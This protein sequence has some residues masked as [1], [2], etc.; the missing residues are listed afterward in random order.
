MKHIIKCQYNNIDNR[1][2]HYFWFLLLLFILS[3]HGPL[4]GQDTLI[5]KS[6][7]TL[8]VYLVETRDTEVEY[9]KSPDSDSRYI[10]PRNKI[11]MLLPAIVQETE[12][13]VKNNTLPNDL[14][15]DEVKSIEHH[16]EASYARFDTLNA[17]RYFFLPS[18]IPLQKKGIYYQNAFL[19]LNSIN[20]GVSNNFSVGGGIGLARLL[21]RISPNWALIPKVGF[22]IN[23]TNYA[24]GGMML[25]SIYNEDFLIIPYGIYTY[26]NLKRNISIGAGYGWI[27]NEFIDYP[28]VMLAGMHKLGKR[29]TL[30]TEHCIIS[31][32]FYEDTYF[33]ILGI[34]FVAIKNFSFDFGGIIMPYSSTFRPSPYLGLS[35]CL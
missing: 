25:V 16:E 7:D 11:S 19:F 14:K 31:Y 26:G 29:F 3:I 2:L 12:D 34:K 15:V 6:H 9:R 24:G 4:M 18:A 17:T 1:T 23:E 21:F 28:T 13:E 5:L 35:L 8:I 22:Q 32:P 20:Y 33:G 27:N 30:V 10:M